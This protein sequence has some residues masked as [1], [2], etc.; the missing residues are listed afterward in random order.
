MLSTKCQINIGILIVFNKLNAILVAKRREGV[1][2]R[3]PPP[4]DAPMISY[5]CQYVCCV[6]VGYTR[7]YAPVHVNVYHKAYLPTLIMFTPANVYT[8]NKSFGRFRG[9]TDGVT[10]CKDDYVWVGREIGDKIFRL[11]RPFIYPKAIGS[12]FI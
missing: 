4:L 11:Q 5:A 6:S 2:T 3:Y 1:R 7:E 9:M 8:N 12:V 10:D